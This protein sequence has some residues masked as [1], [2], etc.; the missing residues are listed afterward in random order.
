MSTN[1]SLQRYTT[2]SYHIQRKTA[3]ARCACERD[4]EVTCCCGLL[5]RIG[6]VSTGPNLVLRLQPS[7]IA[8]S[9]KKS[10]HCHQQVG[11][12]NK[13]SVVAQ[14]LR[15]DA[16]RVATIIVPGKEH[17]LS[18][19]A[20]CHPCNVSHLAQVWR[21]WQDQLQ[22]TAGRCKYPLYHC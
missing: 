22:T 20:T 17:L 7:G 13:A 6:I 3:A 19:G 12:G 2:C 8:G 11:F 5:G 15:K 1:R 18:P 10:E 4:D 16:E 21:R 14:S 9:S